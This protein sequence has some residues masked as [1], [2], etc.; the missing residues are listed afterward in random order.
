MALKTPKNRISSV[1]GV[2]HDTAVSNTME[3]IPFTDGISYNATSTDADPASAG[4]YGA[5]STLYLYTT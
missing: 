2:T 5:T 3:G 4:G 1:Y